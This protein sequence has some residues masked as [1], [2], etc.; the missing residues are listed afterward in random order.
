MLPYGH[1]LFTSIDQ[2]AYYVL[3]QYARTGTKYDPNTPVRERGPFYFTTGGGMGRGKGLKRPPPCP[4][5][6][7]TWTLM[8]GRHLRT[9]RRK[10]GGGEGRGKTKIKNK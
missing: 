3:Y 2:Y 4:P 7:L 8:I 10:R 5:L 1:I 6:M 9:L